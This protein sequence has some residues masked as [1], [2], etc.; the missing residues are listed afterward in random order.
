MAHHRNDV[1]ATLEVGGLELAGGR[2]R[3][4]VSGFEARQKGVSGLLAVD[5]SKHTAQTF[6][7][8]D[9]VGDLGHPVDACI[10]PRCAA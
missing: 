8:Q 3:P 6:V 1:T 5:A 10:S 2:Q 9:L 4:D 7:R